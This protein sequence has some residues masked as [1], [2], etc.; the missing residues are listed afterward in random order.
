MRREPA[1]AFHRVDSMRDDL[2]GGK[3]T[4]DKHRWTRI[5]LTRIARIPA[6]SISVNSRN[7]RKGL[8]RICAVL[9]HDLHAS[10]GLTGLAWLIRQSKLPP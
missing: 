1:Q 3:L 6:N 4:T 10:L 5:S 9:R 2:H 7:S 8:I